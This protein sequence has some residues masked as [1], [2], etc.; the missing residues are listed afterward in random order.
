MLNRERYELKIG[1]VFVA[2]LVFLVLGLLWAKRYR[3]QQTQMELA[4][5]FAAVG[6]LAPG[7][8]VL[9]NGLRMGEV[10]AILLQDRNVRV[11]LTLERTITLREGYEI[12]IAN[13]SFTGEMG[14]TV[15]PGAGEPLGKPYPVL[16]GIAPLGLSDVIQPGIETMKSVSAVTETLMRALPPLLHNTNRTLDR[17]D[18]VFAEAKS[19]ISMNKNVLRESLTQLRQT[20]TTAD[21]IISTLDVRVDTTM[22]SADAAFTALKAASD[23]LRRSATTLTQAQGTLNKLVHDPTLYNDLRRASL[24]LDSAAVSIDSLAQD[25]RRNPKR[26]VRF[27]LF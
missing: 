11:D 15:N 22:A 13:L 3:P 2:A 12:R 7:D 14:V 24:H 16:A 21:H 1:V 18:S 17:L 5:V 23:S 10:D 19:G 6:G 8:E 25:V 4:V 9:V 27:S 26:Y 20:L